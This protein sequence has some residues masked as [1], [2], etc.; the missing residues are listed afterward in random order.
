MDPL[1]LIRLAWSDLRTRIIFPGLLL[2]MGAFL[3]LKPITGGRMICD[4][5]MCIQQLT[6]AFGTVQ[7]AIIYPASDL[8]EF[9]AEHG[10]QG[11]QM[12]IV[13]GR[14]NI[15]H[16]L[17]SP[18]TPNTREIERILAE[19]TRF[20]AEGA[21]TRFVAAM[22]VQGLRAF[23]QPV[24]LLMLIAGAALGGHTL[25]RIPRDQFTL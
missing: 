15:Y 3:A 23:L 6:A 9:R 10:V 22:E 21:E 8:T 16:P 14:G 11:T 24:A 19:G 13:V 25:S 7:E 18:F 4:Q 20:V 2:A 5:G 12:R 1:Q 17:T